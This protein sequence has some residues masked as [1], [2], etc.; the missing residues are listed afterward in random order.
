MTSILG[1]GELKFAKIDATLDGANTVLAA[2]AGKKLRIINYVVTVTVAG[3]LEFEDGAGADLGFLSLG[4]NG[5]ASFDGKL[6]SPAFETA[7]GQ[8]F[9]VRTIATQDAK[10]HLCYVE[11]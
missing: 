9:V 7:A 10:G 6:E 5:G 8:S 3:V 1:L 2:V 4:A 11:I